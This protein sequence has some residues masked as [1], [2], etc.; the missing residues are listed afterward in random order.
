ML[1]Q[2]RYLGNEAVHELKAPSSDELRLAIEIIEHV[3][4]QLYEIPQKAVAL[5]RTIAERKK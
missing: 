2:H 5:K 3:V 1:H 4:E